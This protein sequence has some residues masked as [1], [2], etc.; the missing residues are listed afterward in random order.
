MLNEGRQYKKQWQHIYG[1]GDNL[2]K[3]LCQLQGVIHD[4]HMFFIRSDHFAA[5]NRIPFKGFHY[6]TKR[7]PEDDCI[8]TNNAEDYAWSE[9]TNTV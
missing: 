6:V 1:Y 9:E 4:F 3:I 7:F 8:D 2:V 5:E